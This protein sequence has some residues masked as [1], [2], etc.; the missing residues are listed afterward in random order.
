MR[1]HC[2]LGMK[3]WKSEGI[4][5]VKASLERFKSRYNELLLPLNLCVLMSGVVF[6]Q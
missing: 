6:S 3:R 5:W 4:G 1:R 2:F